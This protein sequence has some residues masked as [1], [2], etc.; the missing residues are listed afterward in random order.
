MAKKSTFDISKHMLVPKHTK[1]SQKDKKTLFSQYNMTFANLPKILAT[2]PALAALNV[3]E[4]DV[5]KVER[6][7][8]TSG[9]TE[10]YRGVTSE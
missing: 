7:S 8:P 9:K 4:G 1:L 6:E 2:D 10:Y 5:I 3:K